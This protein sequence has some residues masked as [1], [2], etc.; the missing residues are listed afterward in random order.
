MT[1]KNVYLKGQRSQPQSINTPLY[2]HSLLQLQNAN[3]TA[4]NKKR[5]HAKNDLVIYVDLG[6]AVI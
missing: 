6:H 2:T 1:A 5:M 4:A 3:Q